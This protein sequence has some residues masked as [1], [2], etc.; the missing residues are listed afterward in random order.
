MST[1]RDRIRVTSAVDLCG[2][3]F[4]VPSAQCLSLIVFMCEYDA[5]LHLFTLIAELS[6]ISLPSPLLSEVLF[7]LSFVYLFVC[8][9]DG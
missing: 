5:N 1:Q 3:F 6:F 9:L 4:V 7:S 8:L 2:A